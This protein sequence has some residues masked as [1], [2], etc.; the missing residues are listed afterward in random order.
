[1][2]KSVR[3]I[4][5]V[6]LVFLCLGL[7]VFVIAQDDED[8]SKSIKAERFV[9]GRPA[10]KSVSRATYRR[11][12]SPN[13]A[14]IQA[15]GLDVARVGI[16]IWRLRPSL[17][18]DKT[19]ELVEEEDGRQSEWTPERVQEGTALSPGQRV[20]LSIESL[21]RDGYLYVVDR[22]V[23]GDQSLGD[24]VLIFPTH[25]NATANYVQAGR[26]IY[27]PSATGRFR[28]KPT[29]SSKE[30]V[31]EVLTLIVSPTPLFRADQLGETRTPLDRKQ[32]EDWQKRWDAAVWKFELDGGVG[33][34]MTPVEQIAGRQDSALLTQ[35]DP[36]PQTVFQVATN[37]SE[38]LM[39]TVPLRFAKRN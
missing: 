18:A 6:L 39:I 1:M 15:K 24:P 30:H 29:E 17:A 32:V 33:Q 21:S 23:Y 20:R 8:D 35:N 16:T 34:A 12:K 7:T 22:E 4:A 28:I 31:A 3:R 11:V 37:P 13:T 10:N 27:I 25:K 36:A 14:S 26:L 9:K 38:P 19:K 2:S 5:P